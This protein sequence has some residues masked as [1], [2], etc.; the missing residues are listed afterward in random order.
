MNSLLGLSI[1]RLVSVVNYPADGRESYGRAIIQCLGAQDFLEVVLKLLF[2][3][4]HVPYG[5]ALV[6]H[7]H[8]GVGA[9]LLGS[10]RA[11]EKGGGV[12]REERLIEEEEWM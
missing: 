3:Q 11:T 1:L 8:V 9:P 5:D 6:L 12:E 7:H 2:S 4:R 10:A